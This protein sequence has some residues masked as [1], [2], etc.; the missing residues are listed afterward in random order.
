MLSRS[1]PGIDSSLVTAISASYSSVLLHI[2]AAAAPRTTYS[3]L[4]ES[5]LEQIIA[6]KN[7]NRSSD[8]PQEATSSIDQGIPMDWMDSSFEQSVLDANCSFDLASFDNFMLDY[9]YLVD[10]DQNLG[11]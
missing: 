2:E 10:H 9:P 3:E 8:F 11:W 7:Q 1:L 6:R 5:L 4:F